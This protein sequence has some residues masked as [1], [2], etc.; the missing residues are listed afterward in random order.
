MGAPGAGPDGESPK[1]APQSAPRVS[2]E[3]A[4]AAGSL[5]RDRA[6]PPAIYATAL[7]AAL[8]LRSAGPLALL[9][10]GLLILPGLDV[11]KDIIHGP[12]IVDVGAVRAGDHTAVRL[13]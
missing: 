12:A 13:N 11:S 10:A 5:R 9:R 2:G 7:R 4:V 3:I 1:S 8:R 6:L